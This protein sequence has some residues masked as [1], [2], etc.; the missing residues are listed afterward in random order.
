MKFRKVYKL[1]M[2]SNLIRL[3]RDLEWGIARQRK[4][5]QLCCDIE[6]LFLA[7]LIL[8]AIQRLR[9]CSAIV[10]YFVRAVAW[11]ERALLLRPCK[12]IF[13]RKI[14]RGAPLCATPRSPLTL[15]SP[16]M[17]QI[18]IRNSLQWNELIFLF[19]AFSWVN[20]IFKWKERWFDW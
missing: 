19:T 2:N 3:V 10:G 8:R 15:R 13:T 1:L 18:V 9:W 17:V 5:K 12:P 16:C 7:I 4:K 6:N 20:S 14:V 11:T